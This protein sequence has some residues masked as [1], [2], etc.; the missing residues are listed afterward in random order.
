MRYGLPHHHPSQGII[1]ID[2][3]I[4]RHMATHRLALF[5][6]RRLYR[7]LGFFFFQQNRTAHHLRAVCLR[8][9][10]RIFGILLQRVVEIIPRFSYQRLT[11]LIP[12]ERHKIVA[13]I[14]S[15]GQY[16]NHVIPTIFQNR[17][18]KLNS[19]RRFRLKQWYLVVIARELGLI[20]TRTQFFVCNHHTA[21][22]SNRHNGVMQT[23][24]QRIQLKMHCQRIQPASMIQL[25]CNHSVIGTDRRNDQLFHFHLF[26]LRV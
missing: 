11:I 17:R 5:D 12:L 13:P 1:Q 6:Q 24:R 16:T 23:R 4:F 3:C 21:V 8:K 9:Q 10:H 2:H 15:A 20:H 14:M 22:F 26:H 19:N 18:R 25:Q 7:N